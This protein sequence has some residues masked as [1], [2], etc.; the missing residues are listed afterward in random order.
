MMFQQVDQLCVVFPILTVG[1]APHHLM[2]LEASFLALT[3]TYW[4][5]RSW[6]CKWR[7]GERTGFC[8]LK[9]VLH[10]WSFTSRICSLL[11]SEFMNPCINW[12]KWTFFCQSKLLELEEEEE[13]RLKI[14]LLNDIHDRKDTNT[15][16]SHLRIKT[17]LSCKQLYTQPFQH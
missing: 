6:D 1:C 2:S 4:R 14:E 15:T 3:D 5:A 10:T 16:S 9:F 17:I 11:N 7:L 13:N 8:C 12:Y